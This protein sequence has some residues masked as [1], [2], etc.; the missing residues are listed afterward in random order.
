MKV[1]PHLF[2]RDANVR[3]RFHDYLKYCE[4]VQPVTVG[5]YIE[6]IG[7]EPR[8]THP[9][10]MKLARDVID[11]YEAGLL[12]KVPLKRGGTAFIRR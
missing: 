2:Y 4:T 8:P 10:F 3:D 11:T 7:Y 5:E 9:A 6:R 1:T 12:I